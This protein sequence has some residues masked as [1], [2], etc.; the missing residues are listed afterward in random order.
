MKTQID[1]SY[2]SRKNDIF[3]DKEHSVLFKNSSQTTRFYN[4]EHTNYVSHIM[5]ISLFSNN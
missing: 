1:T 2:F 3:W 5:Y 4:G